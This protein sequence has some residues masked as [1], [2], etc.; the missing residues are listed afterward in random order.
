MCERSMCRPR[1]SAGAGGLWVNRMDWRE[2]TAP[3]FC[4]FNSLPGRFAA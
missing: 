4:K 2:A 3:R 1:V